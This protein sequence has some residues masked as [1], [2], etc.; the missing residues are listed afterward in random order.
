M[1]REWTK[2]QLLAMEPLGT[3][4]LISAA[5]GSGKTATLTERII[6]RLTDPDH[7]AELSRMLIITFT[8]A[9]TA[10]LRQRISDALAKAIAADP[11]NRHLQRQFIGLGGA[12]ISTIDAFF[13]EPVKTHFAECG[14]PSSFRIADEAELL[15]LCERVM[16]GLIDEYYTKYAQSNIENNVFSL[17]ADNPFADL[18]D[19]LTSSKN[20]ENLVST[21]LN[22]YSKLLSYPIGLDRLSKEA[23]DLRREAQEDFLCSTHGRIIAKRLE[24]MCFSYLSFYEAACADIATDPKVAKKYLPSFAYDC[25]FIK[26][27]QDL[28]QARRFVDVHAHLITYS[29]VG[30]TGIKN[31]DPL[32]AFYRDERAK[33]KD[34]LTKLSKQYTMTT[35]TE[36]LIQ[37][38]RTALMCDVLY[39]LLTEYD[40]RIT[41]EKR[42]RGIC[43]FDD[44][45]RNFLHLLLDNNGC[46]TDLAHSYLQDFDE[47]YIDEYQ[48]VDEMQDTIFSLIGGDHRFMVG[49]IKQSIYGFRGADPTVFARYRRECTLLDPLHPDERP[50]TY[51]TGA[52][53]F[54]S[55][56]FRC[57]E[58]VIRVTNA[59]CSHIFAACPDTI[60]YTS[61]DDL[62]FA[63]LK[64]S[65]DYSSPKVEVSI[66]YKESKEAKSDRGQDEE[67]MESENVAYEAIQ[68]ANQIA[69]LLRSGARLADGTPIRPENIAI[70][71][72]TKTHLGTFMSAL[73]AMG[74]PTGCGELEKQQAGKDILH[75]TDMMYLLNLLRVIDNPDA[76]I[77][78]SEVLRAPFPGMTLEDLVILREHN[79]STHSLYASVEAYAQN[80]ARGN[81]EV[82]AKA[83]AFCTWLENYRRLSATLSADALLR[84]LRQDEHCACRTSQ[85]FLY[86][87]DSAR[88]CR[89]SAFSGV[90]AFL[91]YF[92][93][94][95]ETTKNVVIAND[96]KND[97][98]TLMTI[99]NSKG[100][101]FPVCFV[102]QCGQ[103]FS[104]RSIKP[105]LLFE[106]Q[107]GLAIKLYD[108][109]HHAKTNTLLRRAT[110]MAITL[111]EREEEM[112][113]LYV[114]MTRARERLYISGCATRKTIGNFSAGDRFETLEAS[115]YL[116][117][118][119][120]GLAA[121]PEVSDFVNVTEHLTADVAPHPPLSMEDNLPPETVAEISATTVRYQAILARHTPPSPLEEAVRRVPTKVPAS[122]LTEHLLDECV[123]YQSDRPVGDEDKFP[124]SERGASGVDPRTL[125][126]I[127]T[128]VKLMATGASKDEFELLLRANARPKAAEKG[129]AIHMFLQY[130]DYA[131][132]QRYG[133]DDEIA[134]LC[135]EG[136]INDRVATILDRRRVEAFFSSRF[137]AHV[138]EAQ[139]IE[140]ELRF[141]RFMPLKNLTQNPILAEALGERTLYVQ[142][143]IDLLCEFPD[144][145]I[146]LC[147]YKTDRLTKEER[148]DPLLLAA[149]MQERHGHQLAQYVT[150]IEEM[151]LRKPTH[152]YI[153]SVP[154]G[155]AVEIK[156]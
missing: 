126:S 17:L 22:L 152:V 102:V 53:I 20:D 5:A 120:A 109:T 114:A 86:L 47:V 144:G 31:I 19:S 52:S 145:H 151:Y 28:V 111:T 143:A 97:R 141:T 59:V 42:T 65:D 8:R 26:K 100:L 85:A 12:H 14:F 35:P 68:V 6:R 44:N 121:H 3:T 129:T 147:D 71:A 70:L 133:V 73:D 15:P 27:L 37:M 125:E 7:P 63:K 10:E 62:G 39:D 149:H 57:D 99:H 24:E 87:Y 82:K 56:N 90:Y 69:D 106:K 30:L 138:S 25:D 148:D 112:R 122:R 23:D 132:V 66:L 79:A 134:R 32:F 16:E 88:N 81:E 74:I 1:G 38:E 78:L 41:E 72:R 146:E 4:T 60:A 40:R 91:R 46:P 113:L 48:D 103:A 105:D 2:A 96:G 110:S 124:A 117:W 45:R 94:K 55:D 50:T 33:R 142:G 80:D 21:L 115:S 84:Q 93:K 101:E 89:A 131:R 92:E 43:T 154:L 136:F 54:M 67:T 150:A 119:T 156:V 64:P 58:S 75:G 107:T 108:R 130:C 127:R 51:S 153:Y 13:Y 116:T 76:D 18:C 140:R 118:I 49:D 139:H 137:F 104:R 128:S 83:M 155:E 29:P 123:F 11:A 36:I 61:D 95:L 34:R 9:A 135:H 77:P 98:V